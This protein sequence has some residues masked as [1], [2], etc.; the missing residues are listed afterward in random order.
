[1]GSMVMPAPEASLHTVIKHVEHT[2]IRAKVRYVLSLL[3]LPND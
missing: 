3:H 2:H 1:M